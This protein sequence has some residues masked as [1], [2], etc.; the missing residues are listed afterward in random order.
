MKSQRI[1]DYIESKVQELNEKYSI[2]KAA[3]IRKWIIIAGD[4]SR[5]GGHLTPTMKLRR[6]V[7]SEMYRQEIEL[8]YTLPKL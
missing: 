7:V 2:S 6:K 8:L 5:K 4:F 1:L 3:Q